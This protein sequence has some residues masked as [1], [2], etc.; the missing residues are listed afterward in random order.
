MGSTE[1]KFPSAVQAMC[2]EIFAD[3]QPVR[4]GLISKFPQS[5]CGSFVTAYRRCL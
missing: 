2:M 4:Q 3:L 1:E 5:L